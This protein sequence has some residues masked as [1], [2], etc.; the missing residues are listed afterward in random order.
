MRLVNRN[1]LLCAAALLVLVTATTARAGIIDPDYERYLDTLPDDQLVS[2]LIHMADQVPLTDLDR[3]LRDARV[4]LQTRHYEVVTRLQ[5]VAAASQPALLADLEAR[6]ASG[7]VTGY[8]G[9]WIANQVVAQMTVAAV[10]EVAARADVGVVYANFT[11]ELIEPVGGTPRVVS[12]GNEGEGLREGIGITPGLQAINADRVWHELGITGAG[13]LVSNMDTGVYGSHPALVDRW[14]G[15]HVPWQHAWL[16]VLGNGTTFP[17]D[18]YG[19]GTHVMG[20]LTGLGVATVDTVGVAWGA[21]WIACNAIDQ[22]VGSE[23]D[24]DVITCFQWLSDPDG[25]PQ[26]V[27]DVPDVVQNSWRI[28]EGFPGGYTDCDPRWWAAMDGCEAAGCAVVFSAGNEGSAPMTIGSPPDRITTPTNAFAIGALDATHYSFPYPIASFSSR[29][30]SGCDGITKK[31]E[32]SAPGVEVYSSTRDGSYAQVNWSGTSMAGPH[33]SGIFALLREADPNLDVTTMKQILMDTAVDLG[34]P[35]EDN[36]FGWGIVDAYAAVSYALQGLVELSGTVT[37]ATLGAPVG[38]ATVSIPGPDRTFTTNPLGNYNGFA[39]QGTY[40]VLCEHP[41]FLSAVVPGVVFVEGVPVDLDF[42]LDPAPDGVAPTIADVTC[43]YATDDVV[44]PYVIGATVT[45][46]LGF[47]VARLYYRIDG[48]AWQ[49]PYDMPM[50]GADRFEGEIPG[51]ALGSTVDYYVEALDAQLNSTTD[52]AGAPGIYHSFIINN[53][54]DVFVDDAELDTGWTLGLVG[55]TATT[56]QWERGD[57]EQTVSTSTPQ[58][59][60]QPEDDHTIDPGHIAFVTTAAAGSGPGDND[61]DG[62]FTT[63]VS[64][65]FDVSGA[66]EAVVRYWRWYTNETTLDDI[67]DID[68]SSDGGA[69]WQPLDRVGPG[70]AQPWILAE[71]TLRCVVDLTDQMQLRFIARDT[72]SGSLTEALVDDVTIG[73]FEPGSAAIEEP[74]ATPAHRF[75][76]SAATP[77]PFNPYTVTAF[78]ITDD[79]QV[80]LRVYDVAGRLVRT[81]ADGAF[82][83]GVHRIAFDGRNDAGAALSSGTYFL[84]LEAGERHASRKLSLVR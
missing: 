6:R 83:A 27:D 14:R 68:V 36:T 72:G 35:G 63:L 37:H 53:A 47:A 52:P 81:L 8:T 26:T 5:A 59:I 22:S 2:V 39:P 80:T 24:N 15:N 40:D 54:T 13:R 79:S 31:P 19:H 30:P 44:G 9:Y 62:G 42:A 11:A 82:E 60:Y 61:V 58:I 46:D 55:D 71:H 56:G 76:L 28:N 74:L 3:Q 20:T 69:T 64:P 57:P 10:R 45:D 18:N 78:E 29:G 4:T 21:E 1:A 43:F 7:E 17:T 41:A 12:E 75:R 49:G 32:V 34:D 33:V 23:F 73:I 50:V 25:D 66:H 70:S 67:F 51:Q 65:I 16:D 77:N 48:G 38:G 84:R